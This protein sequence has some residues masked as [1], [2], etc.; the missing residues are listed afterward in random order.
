MRTLIYLLLAVLFAGLLWQAWH[1]PVPAFR[2][3]VRLTIPDDTKGSIRWRVVTRRVI[4][5]A[6]VEDMETLF[7]EAGLR[8]QKITRFET[9]VLHTFRDKRT[10]M[11]RRR[12]VEAKKAWAQRGMEPDIVEKNGRFL[13][14]LGQTAT[15]EEAGRLQ[16]RLRSTT[17]PFIYERQRLVLPVYR[18]VFPPM[19]ADAARKLWKRVADMGFAEPVLMPDGQFR[20][21][22]KG[23]GN[24][25]ADSSLR[26]LQGYGNQLTAW[27]TPA[28]SGQDKGET[29]RPY[30][31]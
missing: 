20:V 31:A 23:S 18:F 11:T 6:A 10:F 9:I 4:S 3:E 27:S 7:R 26:F 15:A 28:A 24:V 17:L 22:Y 1:P 12:A 14:N 25:P 19:P 2:E 8:P 29:V 13:L 5:E 16:S 30:A 21:L